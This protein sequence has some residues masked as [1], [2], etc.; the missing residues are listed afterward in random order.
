M[1]Q[2]KKNKSIVS[3]AKFSTKKLRNIFDFSDLLREEVVVCLTVTFTLMFVQTGAET[4][5]TPLSKQLFEWGELPNS[6]FYSAAG[7]MVS[8][9]A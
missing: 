5:V 2:L 9:Y 7:V 4:L 6:I 8:F 3:I 1:L